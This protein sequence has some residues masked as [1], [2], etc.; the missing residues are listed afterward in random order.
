MQKVI[1]HSGSFH[2]DDV[3]A[4]ATLQLHFGVENIEV[5]RTRDEEVIATG[6]IVVD[7]GGVFDPARGRFDHH[8]NGAPVRDNGIPL[9][10]L[11][12]IWNEYGE[13]L[14]GS[15]EVA[16]EIER[17]LVVPIDAVDN[18]VSIYE[19]KYSEVSPVTIHDIIALMRLVSAEEDLHKSFLDACALARQILTMSLSLAKSDIAERQQAKQIYDQAEDKR[20]LVSDKHISAHFF[21]EYTD[22]LFLVSPRDDGNWKATALRISS[23]AFD[24]RKPF[25]KEW[26]GLRNSDLAETS[27]IKD[28]VFCHKTGYLFVAQSKEDVLEAVQKALES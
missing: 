12:M 17:K 2:A 23:E 22:P 5:I 1:T 13:E 6:D 10:A 3:F 25:P 11:G 15:P 20:V 8:Q 16:R 7:V 18:G 26:R 14:S 21:V 19:P 27:G 28:S 4:V 24:T 9:S